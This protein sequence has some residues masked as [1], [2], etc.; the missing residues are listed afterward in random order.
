MCVESIFICTFLFAVNIS[1]CVHWE[2]WI[3]NKC[4]FFFNNS[5]PG[6][7]NQNLLYLNIGETKFIEYLEL[8]RYLA[9]GLS[10]STVLLNKI[11]QGFEFGTVVLLFS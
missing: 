6:V 2:P 1:M 9:R 10:L 7:F 11:I 5:Y 8:S 3:F 4:T